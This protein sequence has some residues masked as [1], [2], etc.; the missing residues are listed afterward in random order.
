MWRPSTRTAGPLAIIGAL[1]LLAAIVPL[2]VWPAPHPGDSYVFGP[3]RFSGI[4][5]ERVAVP[6]LTFAANVLILAALYGLYRRDTTV[7]LR[8][9]RGSAK[10]TIFGAVAWLFGTYLV[11]S[12]GPND[13]L[14]GA[15]GGLVA[16]LALLLTVPGLAAWG[17]G[18]F[19]TGRQQ[20]GAALTGA[21]VL[22]VLYLGISLSGVD[23][24]PVGGFLLAVPTAM[25]SVLIGYDLWITVTP[26]TDVQKTDS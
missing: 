26:P 3:P 10:V 1:C 17:I 2:E 14:G 13:I 15:F 9:Q 16:V 21:P 20:L 22:T 12:A 24:E 23:F 19:Q 5:A 11:T 4:W 8:W 7:M 6:A 18:Y 25:M